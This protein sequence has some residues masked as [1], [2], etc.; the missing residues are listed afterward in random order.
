ML[1]DIAQ[2]SYNEYSVG[3]GFL[4]SSADYQVIK[5]AIFKALASQ[6]KYW[7]IIFKALNLIDHLIRNGS[8]RMI[9]DARDN[10]EKLRSLQE[11]SFKEQQYDRGN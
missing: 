11:F 9:D 5:E 8:P 1:S 4:I 10:I 3:C 6:P 7:K 2:A